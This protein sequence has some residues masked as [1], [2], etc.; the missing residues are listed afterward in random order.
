MKQRFLY[1]VI[2]CLFCFVQAQG[3]AQ[4]RE[5]QRER[6]TSEERIEKQ[7]VHVARSLM[8]GDDVVDKFIP[9]YS[10]YLKEFRSCAHMDFRKE[11]G[12]GRMDKNNLTDEQIDKIISMR[13]DKCRKILD[14]REKYY[15]EFK[16]ILT[17]RQIMKL[18]SIER[19]ISKKVKGEIDRRVQKRKK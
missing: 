8:L 19:S 17:P 9:M 11:F 13:F 1:F 10:N 3:W 18:Y 12:K 15:G 7:A 14:V 16:K 6:L 5:G 2:F 4:T